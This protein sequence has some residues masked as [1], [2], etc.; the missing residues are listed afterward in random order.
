MPLLPRAW[1]SPVMFSGTHH[2]RWSWKFSNDCRVRMSPLLLSTVKIPLRTGQAASPPL[3][4][5]HAERSVPSN[6]T[7]AS[8]G[9]LLLRISPG[10]TTGGCGVQYSDIP[11]VIASGWGYSFC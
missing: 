8:D 6:N 3:A 1:L 5:T 7:T 2:S 9:A 10:A 4:L 11:G